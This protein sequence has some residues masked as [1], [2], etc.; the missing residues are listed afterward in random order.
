MEFLLKRVVKKDGEPRALVFVEHGDFVGIAEEVHKQ[1]KPHVF[2]AF[3]DHLKEVG[4]EKAIE[5]CL[6]MGEF[7]VPKEPRETE[8]IERELAKVHVQLASLETEL[9]RSKEEKKPEPEEKPKAKSKAKAK[10]KSK[11]KAKPEV[12]EESEEVVEEA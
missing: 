12:K 6:A 11:A 8:V 9:D 5:E 1:L 10:S 2:T 3:N 7:R 4:M